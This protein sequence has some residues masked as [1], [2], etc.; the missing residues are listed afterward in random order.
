MAAE[1]AL[2]VRLRSGWL[3]DF[4]REW[5]ARRVEDE[6]LR[7]DAVMASLPSCTLGFRSSGKVNPSR[8]LNPSFPDIP[9]MKFIAGEPMKPATKRLA[10]RS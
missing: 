2:R 6:M 4:D 5:Q 9:A 3:D 10:G 1:L 8:V 7:S